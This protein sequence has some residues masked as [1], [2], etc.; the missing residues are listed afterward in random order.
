MIFDV[1]LS[2]DAIM[3]TYNVISYLPECF[4]YNIISL[5]ITRNTIVTCQG[6]EPVDSAELVCLVAKQSRNRYF[7][8]PS[9]PLP[10][11]PFISAYHS[12]A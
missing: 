9:P 3:R 12:F 7:A 6:S 8:A 2:A 1:T 4:F 11:A 10:L 5:F